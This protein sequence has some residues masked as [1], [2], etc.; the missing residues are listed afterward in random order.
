[1]Y[2]IKGSTIV[3]DIVTIQRNTG[4]TVNYIKRVI[5][6]DYNWIKQ[7]SIN[8]FDDFY[9]TLTLGPPAGWIGT[10]TA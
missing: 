8:I 7:R 4:E 10:A 6:N 1:M 2:Y 9:S 5:N 3:E